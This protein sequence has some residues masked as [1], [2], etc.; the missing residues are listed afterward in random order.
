MN[1]DI[2]HNTD[3][4]I[5][6]ECSYNVHVFQTPEKVGKQGKESATRFPKQ[7]FPT[8]AHHKPTG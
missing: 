3:L 1:S 4:L 6:F 5:I 8:C 2:F 7:Y